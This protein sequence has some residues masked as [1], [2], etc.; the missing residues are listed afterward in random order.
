MYSIKMKEYIALFLVLAIF[1][2]GYLICTDKLE[3]FGWWRRGPG[4]GWRRGPGWGWRR[5]PG[6]RWRR[7]PRCYCGGY[8]GCRC[9][10]WWY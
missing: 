9:G 10:R 7:G 8:G 1:I 5:G 4:W 3:D 6:W 2:I